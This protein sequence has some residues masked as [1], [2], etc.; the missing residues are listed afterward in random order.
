MTSCAKPKEM[1][2]SKLDFDGIKT[3]LDPETHKG[4][5][6]IARD[7]HKNGQPRIEWP[8]KNGLMHGEIRE[9]YS[10]GK[11]LSVTEFKDGERCGKNVEWSKNGEL[12][13][14]RVYDHDR[15]VSEINHSAAK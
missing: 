13:M 12:Y 11:Q 7:N 15:I 8:M 2:L 14:E 10:D 3:F 9:W 1:F 6:G 4:F 5:T